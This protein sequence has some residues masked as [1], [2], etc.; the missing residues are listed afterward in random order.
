MAATEQ[1]TVRVKVRQGFAAPTWSSERGDEIDV[2]LAD[3]RRMVTRGLA[4]P[5]SEKEHRDAY[6][7]AMRMSDAESESARQVEHESEIG[8]HLLVRLGLQT[9][10]GKHRR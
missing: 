1:T 3:A 9:P 10:D 8:E 2:P 5:P 6:E 7:K 4:G